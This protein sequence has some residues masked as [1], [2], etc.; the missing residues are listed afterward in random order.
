MT[1][2]KGRGL[3][4]LTGQNMSTLLKQSTNMNNMTLGA[5]KMAIASQGVYSAEAEYGQ[6][7]APKKKISFDVHDAN[8]GYII[9]V[10]GDHHSAGELYIV[11]EEKNI[12]E[13]IGKIIT[14]YKLKA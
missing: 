10:N 13:E 8:G 9:E 11:G 12:G 1:A 4:Q 7:I 2:F 6:K 5:A 14:H 3:I